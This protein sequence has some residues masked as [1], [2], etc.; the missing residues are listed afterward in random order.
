MV[1]VR[2]LARAMLVDMATGT[3]IQAAM[4][5]AMGIRS[6]QRR[7]VLCCVAHMAGNA[8]QVCQLVNLSLE[9][10]KSGLSFCHAADKRG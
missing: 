9:A 4:E 1:A 8:V 5:V 7:T 2:A 10:A 6:C 3:V